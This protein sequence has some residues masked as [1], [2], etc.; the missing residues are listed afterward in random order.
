MRTESYS[1]FVLF[2]QFIHTENGNDVLERLIILKDLLNS[3]GN[4]VV[5]LPDLGYHL[6]TMLKLLKK[7]TYNSRIQH[8]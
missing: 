8:T 3:S 2:R 1:Q 4:F 7:V 6:D 5:L